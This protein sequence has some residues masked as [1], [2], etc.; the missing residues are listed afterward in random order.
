MI[1][2]RSSHWSL[3]SVEFSPRRYFLSNGAPF[4]PIFCQLWWGASHGHQWSDCDR[5]SPLSTW[6]W[7]WCCQPPSPFSAASLASVSSKKSF[8]MSWYDYAT[9]FYCLFLSWSDFGSRR[10]SHQFLLYSHSNLLT[11]FSCQSWILGHQTFYHSWSVSFCINMVGH[12]KKIQTH[13]KS[14]YLQIGQHVIFS[15]FC[16]DDV[17]D[18]GQVFILLKDMLHQDWQILALAL[19]G[20][21]LELV[22]RRI[23]DRRVAKD[24]TSA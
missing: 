6:C 1:S 2:K 3:S 23:A 8:S 11:V 15:F 20:G 16:I 13:Y 24:R 9:L 4:L 22:W 14:L 18:A 19:L 10:E 21:L 12:V 7:S 5:W 17:L